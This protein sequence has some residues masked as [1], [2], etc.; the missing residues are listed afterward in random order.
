MMSKTYYKVVLQINDTE[1][2]LDNNS[3]KLNY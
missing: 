1:L 3:Y 2:A